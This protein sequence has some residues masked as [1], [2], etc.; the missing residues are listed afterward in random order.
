MN[1]NQFGTTSKVNLTISNVSNKDILSHVSFTAP[2]KIMN[3][4]Y[5]EQ[6]N[7]SVMIMTASAGI[8]EGDCQ[9]LQLD[10]GE[11]ARA[12]IF[13]QSYEKIHKMT[14][15]SATRTTIVSVKHG[16][17]LEYSPLPTIP[18][19][20]SNFVSDTKIYLE[21]KTSQFVFS[22]ILSAGR[23][24]L[25]EM[26]EYSLYQS[27]VSVYCAKELIYFD[28]ASYKPSMFDMNGFCLQEGFSHQSSLLLFNINVSTE[29]LE[30]IQNIID[31]INKEQNI[32]GGYSTT[33]FNDIVI[34]FLGHSGDTL[35][36]THNN[37]MQLLDIKI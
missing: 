3:P 35:Q 13:S 34:R 28:N 29:K 18:F 22:D 1:S 36:N 16:G 11:N 8:M 4:F 5:D 25:G 9:E 37:I 26:F 31:T 23:V 19:A 14:Q 6:N 32:I 21:D 24:A 33:H 27:K 10:I 17:F 12:K 30:Q 20:G 15:G 2:F 7:L